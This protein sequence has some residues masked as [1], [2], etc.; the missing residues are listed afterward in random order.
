[1]QFNIL[2]K[3]K[4][5]TF[6]IILLIKFCDNCCSYSIFSLDLFSIIRCKNCN[7]EI[8]IGC[9]KKPLSYEDYS[10]YLKGF[11]IGSY[12]RA[13]NESIRIMD[14]DPIFLVFHIIFT[15][16][17]KPIYIGFISNMLGFLV[18]PKKSRLKDDGKIHD[19]TYHGNILLK[20]I[21]FSII[22]G[23]LF[24]PYIIIFFPF[25]VILLLPGIFS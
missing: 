23:I 1:M 18:H 16:F 6:Y 22:K 5:T 8:C 21:I 9:K 12:L 10:T 3:N 19:F 13:I 15:L 4:K 20:I 14:D 7:Y 25:M 2:K 17:F 24:F 11:I